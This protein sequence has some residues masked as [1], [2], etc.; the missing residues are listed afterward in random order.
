MSTASEN[1]VFTPTSLIHANRIEMRQGLTVYQQSMLRDTPLHV[2]PFDVNFQLESTTFWD[3]ALQ[4]GISTVRSGPDYNKI[5][6]TVILPDGTDAQLKQRMA[7]G[8][9]GKMEALGRIPSSTTTTSS[10]SKPPTNLYLSIFVGCYD[11]EKEATTATAGLTMLLMN[12]GR[13]KSIGKDTLERDHNSYKEMWAKG[14]R[15]REE[16]A[17]GLR[18]CGGVSCTV[19]FSAKKCSAC[20]FQWY[21]CAEHQ[22]T[23]WS[24][25][26]KQ[27]CKQFR[28]ERKVASKSVKKS[29]QKIKDNHAKNAT[30]NDAF[31][32]SS[33]PFEPPTKEEETEARNLTGMLF[34]LHGNQLADMDKVNLFQVLD[35]YPRWFDAC[36][37][38]QPD[39]F[40]KIAGWIQR[41]DVL[42]NPDSWTLP[43]NPQMVPNVAEWWCSSMLR[44]MPVPGTRSFSGCNGKRSYRFFVDTDNGFLI[45]LQSTLG[46]LQK[47]FHRSVSAQWRGLYD[48]SVRSLLRFL[49]G[50]LLCNRDVGA[51]IVAQK[52]GDKKVQQVLKSMMDL[53][54]DPR[55]ERIDAGSAIE[56][57]TNQLVALLHVWT[58][59]LNVHTEFFPSMKVEGERWVMYKCMAYRMAAIMVDKGRNVNAAEQQRLAQ[60]YTGEM[61]R[62][63]LQIR[64]QRQTKKKK[65]KGKKGKR[66]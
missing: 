9:L 43:A 23:H 2:Y 33:A 37:V 61:D 6:A 27:I 42:D 3:G 47:L 4:D 13:G 52:L 57:L 50:G 31:A 15:T 54:H 30:L 29:K 25:G 21:C 63:M 36:S 59:R 24:N 41:S 11:T 10:S 48:G 58:E 56:G 38:V 22:K 46:A 44:G 51:A 12:I 28:K 26:H 65:G 8:G 45:F 34:D 16:L 66:R 14:A 1:D 60:G 20:K 7:N 62:C 18:P 35:T 19:K 64:G 5:N 40:A 49:T 55:N 17:A 39:F 53:F 32:S